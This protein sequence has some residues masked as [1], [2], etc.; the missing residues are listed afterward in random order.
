MTTVLII[1]CICIFLSHIWGALLRPFYVRWLLRLSGFPKE[2]VDLLE[3]ILKG[4]DKKTIK[5]ELKDVLE[6]LEPGK[7]R[8]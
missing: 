7:V 2:A 5:K 6:T 3:A 8:L 4:A 1:A